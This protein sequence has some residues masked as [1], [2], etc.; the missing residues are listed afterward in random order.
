MASENRTRFKLSHYRLKD[1]YLRFYL[2]YI[3]PNKKKIARQGLKLLPQ[4]QSAMGLQFENLV[5]NNRKTIQ[6]ILHI[7]SSEIAFRMAARQGFEDAFAKGKPVLLEPLMKLEVETPSDFVGRIQSKLLAR[8]AILLGSE[9]RNQDAIIWAEVPLVEMFG[10]AT[11]LRS[12]SQGMATFSMEFAEYRP[13]SETLM[14][15]IR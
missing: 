4:W 2:K 5:L 3:E 7:D 13:I 9:T 12:L 14:A 10:Y 1:N 6:H 11:E 15:Q 8:R